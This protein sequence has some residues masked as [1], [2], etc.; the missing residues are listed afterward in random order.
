M[1]IAWCRSPTASGSRGEIPTAEA[2]LF[3]GDGHVSL[4][5]R[6]DDV[7]ADLVRLGG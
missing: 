6:I 7:L 5:A 4:I 1:R 3:E 2:H